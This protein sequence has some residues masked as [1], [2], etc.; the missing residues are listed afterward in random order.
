[1]KSRLGYGVLVLMIILT[2]GG[3]SVMAAESE[4][5]IYEEEEVVI[6]ATRTKQ[7]ESQAPGKTEV[8]TEAEVE[9][10]GAATVAEVLVG[11]GLVTYN[12][13][14]AAGAVNLQLDGA[15]PAQTL[16]L[17]N[18]VPANAGTDGLVDLS[19]FP[20][21]GIE[22]I[23]IVHGPLSALY[24]ANAM[25]GVVNIIT[26]LTGKPAS[27][28]VFTGGSNS[29]GQFD[30]AIIQ[31]RFGL[32]IGGRA[33]DGYQANSG[34][35]TSYIMGQYDFWQNDPQKLR[36]N[37]TYNTKD[38]EIPR[39]ADDGKKENLAVDLQGK[40]IL[41]QAVIEYKIY[42]QDFNYDHNSYTKTQYKTNIYGADFATGYQV[43]SH[44][45][46]GGFQLQ[47]S[48][49]SRNE[50]KDTWHN[51][52]LFLQDEWQ[53]NPQWQ[54]VS[55]VRWDTG[56]VFSSPLCSRFGLNYALSEQLT[57]KLGYGK[58]FRAPNFDDLYF[59]EDSWEYD[60]K[61]YYSKGNPNLKPETSERYDL[62]GEWRS[63]SQTLGLNCFTAEVIDGIEWN[64]M[65]NNVNSP[66][67]ISKMQINGVSMSWQN[68]FNQYLAVELKYLFTDR[69][70]W[71]VTTQSYSIDKNTYGK[72]RYTLNLEYNRN[73]WDMNLN[74][75]Y[76]TERNDNQG[77]YGVLD[78]NLKYQVNPKLNYGL[79][80]N[81]LT[82]KAYQV[83]DG[84]LMP[85]R[86]YY[87]SANYTF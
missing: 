25:G 20:T 72:N 86:E 24:G 57:V 60:G 21:A 62:T 18:G 42:A 12:T 67:N 50:L 35:N 70:S 87:L 52:A 29:Y 41:G 81:N 58:A 7:A 26:N 33:T 68:Q 36:L 10:S 64:R 32:A 11:E 71:D 23:E 79:T 47:Q 84:Y 51:G 76:I 8:I 34:T 78:L 77:N 6:T 38:F 69:K 45:L 55:G 53:V 2:L 4:V 56:S 44:L 66:L 37:F 17:I 85:G 15:S 63:G 80:I 61:T 49:L 9:A 5:K 27:Q 48:K 30:L 65:E 22:R 31:P 1:M 82:D 3:F 19:Y 16:I 73:P 43:A 14:G 40:N 13:G 83:V 75:T 54:L 59:P 28:G 39:S 46:L 74:W